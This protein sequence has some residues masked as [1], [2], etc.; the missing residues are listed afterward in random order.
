[1]GDSHFKMST[2][3]LVL[4]QSQSEELRPVSSS[5][6]CPL[7]SVQSELP[8]S[9]NPSKCIMSKLPRPFLGTTLVSTS[10]VFPPLISREVSS[11]PIPRE[12]QPKTLTTSRLKLSS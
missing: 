2:R 5:Q 8:P 12:S 6:T 4:E 7:P 1:M 9:A 11:P 3:S 10:R